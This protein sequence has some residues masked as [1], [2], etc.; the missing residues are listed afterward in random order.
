MVVDFTD[1]FHS[2]MV[3]PSEKVYQVAAGFDGSYI[4]YR[5]VVFGGGGSPLVYGGE[6]QRGLAARGRPCSTR[7]SCAWRSTWTTLGSE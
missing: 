1:A 4:C 7:T 6:Q 3:H 2:L 5:M